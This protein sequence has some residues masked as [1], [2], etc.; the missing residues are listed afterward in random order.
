VLPVVIAVIEYNSIERA[1]RMKAVEVKQHGEYR[2][3]DIPKLKLLL[4]KQ[5]L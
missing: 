2:E 3:E 1:E 5:T 4:E